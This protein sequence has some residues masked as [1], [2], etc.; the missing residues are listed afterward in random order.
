MTVGHGRR[1]ISARPSPR[2]RGVA[3]GEGPRDRGLP[4]PGHRLGPGALGFAD[5]PGPVL[6]VILLLPGPESGDRGLAHPAV[7]MGGDRRAA[8][9]LR[10]GRRLNLPGPGQRRDPELARD[11]GRDAAPA[12][13][14]RRGPHRGRVRSPSSGEIGPGRHPRRGGLARRRL[15]H[16]PGAVGPGVVVVG[17]R[18]GLWRLPRPLRAGVDHARRHRGGGRLVR[19][20]AWRPQ[21]AAV[22]RR[23]RAPLCARGPPR[24]GVQPGRAGRRPV[25]L[26]R[27]ARARA[28]GPVGGCRHPRVLS[29]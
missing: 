4:R 6:D 13:A 25:A 11:R 5:H 17:I 22:R 14:R 9:R 1:A 28:A 23:A 16:R 15:D 27:I 2:G 18:G 29:Q 12:P 8:G 10:A 7:A 20:G 21:G 26:S 24:A 3:I 19:V